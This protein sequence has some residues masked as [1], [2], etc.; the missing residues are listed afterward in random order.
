M[1]TYFS[2]SGSPMGSKEEHKGLKPMF[3]WYL[4][5]VNYILS[6]LIEVVLLLN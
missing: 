1:A 4:K 2:V 6:N 5:Q 3:L